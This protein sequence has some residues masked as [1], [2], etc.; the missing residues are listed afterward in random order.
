MPVFMSKQA[1]E[2]VRAQR[3]QRKPDFK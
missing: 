3:E 1:R 2:G